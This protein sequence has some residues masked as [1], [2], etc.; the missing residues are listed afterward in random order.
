MQEDGN[1]VVVDGGGQ[2]L[3]N[4][5]TNGNPGA[6]LVLQQDGNLVVARGQQALWSS[7]TGVQV[8][9]QG[10]PQGQGGF[11]NQGGYGNQGGGQGVGNGGGWR[12][13]Y[14]YGQAGAR[15]APDDMI[16]GDWLDGRRDDL[17]RSRNR[18]YELRMQRDCNLVLY[19]RD[20]PVWESRTDRRGRD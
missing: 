14:G 3:W 11:G 20:R 7:S 15:R 12:Q 4:S 2:P 1:L 17:L 16:P 5:G 8:A 19:A 10:R 6:Q 9:Q 18:Q 13:G